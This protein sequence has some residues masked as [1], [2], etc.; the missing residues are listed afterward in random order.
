VSNEVSRNSKEM[1]GI[2][3]PTRAAGIKIKN[4]TNY[5]QTKE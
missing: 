4:L 2:W 1:S 3:M 5:K